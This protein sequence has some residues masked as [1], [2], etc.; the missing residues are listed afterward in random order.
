[1]LMATLRWT[2]LV[3]TAS[4]VLAGADAETGVWAQ[5]APKA[6]PAQSDLAAATAKRFPQPVRVGAIIGQDVLQPTEAQPVLGRVRAV[7]Q[8]SD[9]SVEVIVSTGGLLGSGQRNVAVPA[10]AIAYL[11][12]QV[13]LIGYTPEQLASLP[14]TTDTPS[15][16]ETATIKLGIVR[17]FH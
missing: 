15:L 9:G 7:R 4:V 6:L 10:D 1:M 13:A 8:A 12:P 5:T 16:P 2:V 14:S 11:G 3:L 17:P